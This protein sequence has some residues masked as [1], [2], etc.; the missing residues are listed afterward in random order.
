MATVDFSKLR[1]SVQKHS[2]LYWILVNSLGYFIININ[3]GG[4]YLHT[5]H[6]NSIL[7]LVYLFVISPVISGLLFGLIQLGY[8]KINNREFFLRRWLLL[9]SL[10]FFLITL[11]NTYLPL[12]LSQ[13]IYETTNLDF[14]S[15]GNIFTG[16]VIGG[17]MDL[18]IKICI[19]AIMGIVMGIGSGLVLGIFPSFSILNKEI[20]K[21][22]IRRVVVSMCISF[23]VDSIFYTVSNDKNLLGGH[24]ASLYTFGLLFTGFIYG[25]FTRST[26]K[27]LIT[28]ELMTS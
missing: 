16:N 13:L 28:R 14:P 20:R 24:L 9:T 8:M 26:I 5:I 2:S 1:S 4:Q 15:T 23:V 27:K 10:S 19:S 22:W 3:I 25:V 18:F 21:E 7:M 11:I 17:E 12:F 6:V